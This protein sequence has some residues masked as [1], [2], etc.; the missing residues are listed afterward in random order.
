MRR[1]VGE[2][3]EALARTVL[4]RSAERRRGREPAWWRALLPAAVVVSSALVALAVAPRT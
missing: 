4:Q 1:L 3:N 2:E